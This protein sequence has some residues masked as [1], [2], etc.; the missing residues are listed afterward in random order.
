MENLILYQ[1]IGLAIQGV[2]T[3][4]IG[5]LVVL[6]FKAGVWKG[7]VDQD[8]RANTLDHGAF[9]QDIRDLRVNPSQGG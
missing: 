8:R 7:E 6:F 9:R 2:M 4:G 1:Q 5:T 3:L